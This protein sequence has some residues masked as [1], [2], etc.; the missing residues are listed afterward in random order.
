[1]SA[2]HFQWTSATLTHA[3]KVRRIN[4][5]ACLELPWKGLWVVADGMGGHSAGD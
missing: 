2:D 3:G 5:D 4:E 1:M